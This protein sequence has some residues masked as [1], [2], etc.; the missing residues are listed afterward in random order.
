MEKHKFIHGLYFSHLNKSVLDYG[1]RLISPGFQSELSLCYL[2]LSRPESPLFVSKVLT[3]LRLIKVEF[4]LSSK[5]AKSASLCHFQNAD[6]QTKR[7]NIKQNAR[8]FSHS[9]PKAT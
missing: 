3:R 4:A 8:R 7:V 2:S 6:I 9:I 5:I 1:V